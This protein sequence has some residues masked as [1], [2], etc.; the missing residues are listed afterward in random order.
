MDSL[1]GIYENLLVL[2]FKSLYPSI[3]RTFNID[4]LA[5][6]GKK[7][8]KSY[9]IAPNKAAFKRNSALLP[10]IIEVLM[11]EREKVAKQKD[12]LTRYA[13][14]ILL[15]S[16]FGVMANPSFRFFNTDMAN[17]ITQSGQ[18][19]IKLTAKKIEEKGYKVIY[20]DT[21]SVFINSK[22]DSYEKSQKL[23]EK[24]AKDINSFFDKHIKEKY[25]SENYL[26]LEFEKVFKMFLMPHVRGSETGAKKRYA[27]LLI[28]DG[29]EKIE[30]TGLESRRRDWTDL[31]K[32]FQKELLD[33]IFHKKTVTNYIKKF[34]EDIRK[35]KYDDLLIYR[36]AI[37]KDLKSYA[38]NAQHVKAAQKLDKM[39]SN[40]I[41]YVITEDGP[42]PTQKLK[43]KIDYDHYIKKQI[44]P[45]ADSVL[46]FF[47][48]NF[49]ELLKGNKQSSLSNF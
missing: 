41:E 6:V 28:K 2:D 25:N 19:L 22:I 12:E 37:R 7:K 34:V 40:I 10:E 23:G 33:L 47:N 30:F 11:K 46:V 31:S 29:K 3:I 1:P 16:F 48:K 35:G 5:F 27:G 24:L 36:K 49:E 43:H 39:D 4:P 21:D 13:I 9:I 44:Q 42:E 8:G 18:E 17:A 38:I 45:I 32:K 20:S 26:E 15:N 14:K